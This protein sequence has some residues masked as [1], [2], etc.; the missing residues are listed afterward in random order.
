MWN[1]SLI[2]GFILFAIFLWLT[3]CKDGKDTIRFRPELA[4]N[5]IYPFSSGN[6]Y[7]S[8][9]EVDLHFSDEDGDIGLTEKDSMYPFGL[10]DPG[11]YNLFVYYQHKIGGIWVY[12]KNPL[13]GPNDT[14]VLHERL[15]NI[16]PTGRHKAIHGDIQLIIPARPYQYRGDSVRFEIQLID[17]AL[18]RSNVILTPSIFLQHP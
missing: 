15:T 11:F 8:F 2:S 9:V 7:D 16:T 3:G 12:P 13:L 4:L 1:K 18:Q 14:L 5:G 17:R 6:G 10:G